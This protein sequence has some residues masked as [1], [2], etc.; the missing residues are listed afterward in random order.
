MN[1]ELAESKRLVEERI[2]SEVKHFA[3][4]FGKTNECGDVTGAVLL[5]LG[6]R[7]AV[8][9]MWGANTR[10]VHPYRLRRVQIGDN[11]SLSMFAL[12]LTRLLLQSDAGE[13]YLDDLVTHNMTL[14]NDE[15][16]PEAN[17]A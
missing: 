9:T 6:F 2:Q 5:R 16:S 4:P 13:G 8:T 15:P 10:S 17:H 12:R 3:Y 11:V 7:S 14:R 1:S